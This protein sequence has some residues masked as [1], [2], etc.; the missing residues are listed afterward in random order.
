MR[1]EQ[2]ERQLNRDR[3]EESA[4][5]ALL[6]EAVG[7]PSPPD[8]SADILQQLQD[9]P[10]KDANSSDALPPY[11]ATART[12]AKPQRNMAAV[13]SLIAAIAAVVLVVVVLRQSPR[14][15]DG[16]DVAHQDNQSAAAV[17]PAFQRSDEPSPIDLAL[18]DAAAAAQAAEAAS[19]DSHTPPR[20][21]PRSMGSAPFAAS[22]TAAPDTHNA[23][24][25]FAKPA[26]VEPQP[27]AMI[28]QQLQQQFDLAWQHLGVAPTDPVSDDEVA[29]RISQWLDMPVSAEQA[30]DSQA[31]ARL[32]RQKQAGRQASQRLLAQLLGPAWR[33]IQAEPK[34]TLV[35]FVSS[36][37]DEGRGFDALTQQLFFGS[38]GDAAA[39]ASAAWLSALAGE[40]SVPVTQ[41]MGHALLDMDLACAR[42]HDDPIDSQIR[43][44]DFWALAAVFENGLQ[45]S[46]NQS[47]EPLVQ[48]T[49]QA[50][51]P[52]GQFFE[53]PDGRQRV[54]LPAMPPAWL[55]LQPAG[56]SDA[57]S[58]RDLDSVTAQWQDNPRLARSLVNRVWTSVYG[59]PLTGAVSDPD[60]PPSEEHLVQLRDYLAA[61][62]R[63][64]DF[65]LAALFSWVLTAPPMH[66][67]V[68]LEPLSDRAA[69][70]SDEQLAR[71]EFMH[72]TFAG[73]ESAPEKLGF[74]GLLAMASRWNGGGTIESLPALAQPSA[75]DVDY[76]PTNLP[77]DAERMENWLR[78]SFPEKSAAPALPAQW[79]GSID[80]FEQQARHL[81]YA[82]GYWK[83]SGK[84]MAAARELHASAGDPA[85]A[86]KQLWWALRNSR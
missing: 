17:D 8:L 34:Q 84:Q 59:R 18:A 3:A 9:T 28:A 19:L 39:Q 16:P 57:V 52:K 27:A 36:S 64:H 63:A 77:S 23:V 72:R 7:G 81:Y 62:T 35:Q 71:A 65:D 44:Q 43:Q 4:L 15:G 80:D 5:I 33:R 76:T 50:D 86:L 79:L 20:P 24:D 31:I 51:S 42:C 66:R 70:A 2:N 26:A 25:V 38:D 73:Y 56:P 75:S 14:S 68:V 61:Q 60:A 22:E 48:A 37:F 85:I 78:A 83:P 29:Q 49:R 21:R 58:L 32:L 30:G 55:D 6:T 67:E 10:A 47:G 41:Q 74:K 13:L 12:A 82:A 40:R 46:R 1:K 11:S 69:F 45:Y 54:A 53:L